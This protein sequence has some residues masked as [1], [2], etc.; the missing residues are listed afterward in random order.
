[1][2]IKAISF[3]S[4]VIMWDSELYIQGQ[5]KKDPWYTLDTHKFLNIV[6]LLIQQ[7]YYSPSSQ[8]HST[9]LRS[10]LETA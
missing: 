8:S 9:T 10:P 3:I 5:P 1:M 6:L 4:D 2:R 7:S